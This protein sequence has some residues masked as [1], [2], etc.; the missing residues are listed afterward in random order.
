MKKLHVAL[1]LVAVLALPSC[2]A[3][4]LRP[5]GDDTIQ[6]TRPVLDAGGGGLGSGSRATGDSIPDPATHAGE[7]TAATEPP[8]ARGGGALGSGS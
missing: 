4:P 1:L 3:E 2:T 6:F 5:N 8:T 7:D